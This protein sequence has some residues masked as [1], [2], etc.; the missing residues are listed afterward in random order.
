VM[1]LPSVETLVMSAEEEA[2]GRLPV[3]ASSAGRL[4]L[5]SSFW[6]C[7]CCSPSHSRH[8]VVV[9]GNHG[10]SHRMSQKPPLLLPCCSC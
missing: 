6:C 9:L 7:S 4:G 3:A 5:C 10:G 1:M 8:A 2:E